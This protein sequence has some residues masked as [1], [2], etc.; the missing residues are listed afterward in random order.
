[1][2]QRSKK[3][4]RTL[5]TPNAGKDVGQQNPRS[6]LVGMQNGTATSEDS[7]E[8]SYKTKHTLTVRSNNCTPWYLPKGVENLRFQQKPGT[9]M[10]MAV[11]FT[12]AKTWKKPRCPSVGEQIN[13]LVRS[14]EY[15]RV[16]K[17][18]EL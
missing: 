13:K 8:V 1:M 3:M 17:R 9:R 10:F 4:H 12:S 18:N 16:L 2:D 14:K 6:L 7:L 11:L 15:Y 5:T